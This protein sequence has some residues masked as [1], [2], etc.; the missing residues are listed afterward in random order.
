[1]KNMGSSL[2]ETGN[3]TSGKPQPNSGSSAW[4]RITSLGTGGVRILRQV[5]RLDMAPHCHFPRPVTYSLKKPSAYLPP[6]AN[7]TAPPTGK[8][9][10][11]Y[12]ILTRN[13]PDVPYIVK[14]NFARIFRKKAGF[15]YR[16]AWAAEEKRLA[17]VG[18]PDSGVLSPPHE[19]LCKT[20]G[21]DRDTLSQTRT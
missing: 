19:H 1:L 20:A 4:F 8:R 12:N 15:S 18:S 2:S 3:V 7:A 9:G 16:R 10:R 13:I 17:P 6:P 14:R 21:P 11:T 5:V